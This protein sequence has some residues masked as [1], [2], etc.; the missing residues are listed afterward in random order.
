MT[1]PNIQGSNISFYKENENTRSSE[2][3]ERRRTVLICDDQRD[4]FL[5]FTIALQESYMY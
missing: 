1:N 5:M 4:L 3:A 2:L